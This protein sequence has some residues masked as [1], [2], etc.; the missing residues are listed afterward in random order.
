MS[1]P[2]KMGVSAGSI[3]LGHLGMR[4]EVRASGMKRGEGEK[5]L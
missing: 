2:E 1:K 4:E 5:I 3:P